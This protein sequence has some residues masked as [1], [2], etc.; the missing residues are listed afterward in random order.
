MSV[1]TRVAGVDRCR[2]GWVVVGAHEGRVE[3]VLLPDG[4]ALGALALEFDVLAVDIPIGLS[5]TGRRRCDLEARRL[6]GRA[7]SPRP[8]HGDRS[9]ET[10][11]LMEGGN[12]QM[13]VKKLLPVH[14]G[15]ALKE[16]FDPSAIVFEDP[17]VR[18]K[19]AFE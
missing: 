1:G 5:D 11:F 2:G 19:C 4:H 6:L 8:P 17:K 14:P 13:S 3:A 12:C 16:E 18:W 7:R 15:E 9:L 10:Q